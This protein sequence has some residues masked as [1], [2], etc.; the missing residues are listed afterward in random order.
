[1]FATAKK[2]AASTLKSASTDKKEITSDTTPT[3]TVG[4]KPDINTRSKVATVTEEVA[5]TTPAPTGRKPVSKRKKADEEDEEP[6][7]KKK[8]IVPET[9]SS[10]SASS[11]SSSSST[12]TPTPIPTSTPTTA[13]KPKSISDSMAKVFAAPSRTTPIKSSMSL[14]ALLAET[15]KPKPSSSSSST[16]T[17]KPT[18][19]PSSSSFSSTISSPIK[20]ISAS[21]PSLP[22]V[23]SSSS[24]P[25]GVTANLLDMMSDMTSTDGEVSQLKKI[26]GVKHIMNLFDQHE[27]HY[28]AITQKLSMQASIS[29]HEWTNVNNT[30]TRLG[31]SS[32]ATSS[33]VDMENM[34]KVFKA[35]LELVKASVNELKTKYQE[36]M[37]EMRNDYSVLKTAMIQNQTSIQSLYEENKKV[38]AQ[39]QTMVANNME[40]V[41]EMNKWK[42]VMKSASRIV[43]TRDADNDEDMDHSGAVTDSS[44]EDTPKSTKQQQ[45]QQSTEQDSTATT[46]DDDVTKKLT[47]E[48][49]SSSDFEIEYDTTGMQEKPKQQSQKSIGTIEEENEDGV[50]EQEEEEESV[51]K[52]PKPSTP[53]ASQFEG[54]TL[55]ELGTSQDE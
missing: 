6:K 55:E 30:I 32:S 45:Q 5:A 41:N 29:Q 39:Y 23:S 49:E 16:P 37:T 24:L 10:S 12:P 40:L 43:A 7:K 34:K 18:P 53:I 51:A 26:G 28:N 22:D 13:S 3:T 48:E 11:S 54:T 21:T 8:P 17:P 33:S 1:M 9:P 4:L 15:P 46:T 14:T 27:A 19:K 36:E 35:D 52:T 31:K 2:D 25:N 20:V 42:H 44:T 38:A 50:E 47:L